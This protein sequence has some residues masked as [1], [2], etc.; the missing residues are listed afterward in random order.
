MIY[1]L[2]TYN[3]KPNTHAEYE[4]RFARALPVREQYSRLVGF[5]HTEIGP[6]NQVIHLWAYEDLQQRWEARAAAVK[7]ASGKWPP[8]GM[9][10]IESMHSDILTP[11]SV[12][13]PLDGPREWG[14]LYELR[15]YTFPAGTVRGILDEFAEKSVERRKLYPLGGFFASE[16]GE[17]NRFY[18]LWP[19]K[20]W[21]HRDEIRKQAAAAKVWP[22]HTEIRAEH[23]LVR[24]LV[25]ASFSPLH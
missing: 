17:L 23:Q 6:L 9:D 22:P 19:Y 15:M 20:D 18:Q 25:P 11:S 5:W 8:M 24:H 13:D 12:N 3:L 1:E 10:M 7:D 14:N 2:R 21:A 4:R 16:L